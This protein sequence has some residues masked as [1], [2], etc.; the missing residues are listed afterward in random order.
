MLNRPEPVF[1][2][3]LPDTSSTEFNLVSSSTSLHARNRIRELEFVSDSVPERLK[4]RQEPEPCRVDPLHPAKIKRDNALVREADHGACSSSP[5][6]PAT[7]R[8]TQRKVTVSAECSVSNAAG[9]ADV[10]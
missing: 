6:A 9:R 7:R 2:S 8:P 1:A 3:S 5:S 4:E 10:S